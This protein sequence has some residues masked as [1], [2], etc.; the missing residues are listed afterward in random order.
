M[1]LLVFVLVVEID[2]GETISSQQSPP[3]ASNR[4]VFRL[5]DSVILSLSLWGD[6]YMALLQS[7]AIMMMR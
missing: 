7:V 3:P 5:F 2:K 4:G 1:L 6:Y